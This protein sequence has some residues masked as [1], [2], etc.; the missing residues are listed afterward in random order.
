MEL[1]FESHSPRRAHL[2]QTSLNSAEKRGDQPIRLADASLNEAVVSRYWSGSVRKRRSA[3]ASGTR[4]DAPRRERRAS[5]S[6]RVGASR[7][8]PIA[9]VRPRNVK[10]STPREASQSLLSRARAHC[11]RGI[12]RESYG[13]RRAFRSCVVRNGPGVRPLPRV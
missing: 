13:Q 10:P 9:L 1:D 2:R 3:S 7:T 12:A 6:E 8:A 5:E 11:E 4:S